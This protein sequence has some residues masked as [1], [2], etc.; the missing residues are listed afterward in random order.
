LPA[1]A[2]ADEPPP[3]QRLQWG[4]YLGV[5][6]F[7]DDSGLG[8]DE[9]APAG[10]DIK[11]GV[12]LG[13]RLTW[14]FHD[15]FAAEGEIEILPTA[16]Q[17]DRADLTQ[18]GYRAHGLVFFRDAGV[19]VRPFA[20]V[21]VGGRS[22]L[23]SDERVIG[24]GTSFAVD[25]GV[26]VFLGI[27]SRWGL[28][29]DLRLGVGPDQGGTL[30][31]T[32]GE[33][34]VG[35]YFPLGRRGPEPAWAIANRER[36]A[37]ERR[38]AAG[39]AAAEAAKSDPDDADDDGL[40][41]ADDRCPFDAEDKDGVDDGDGCPDRDE[42]VDGDGDGVFGHM[43]KC[44][45]ERETVNGFDD[46]DGCPDR[47][48]AKT[49]EL[50]GTIDGVNFKTG[51]ATI[52]K[53]SYAVLDRAAKLLSD[54]PKLR[55]TIVGHTDDRGARARNVK[56]SARRA[57]AVKKY[58]VKAGVGAERLEAVGKGPDEPLYDNRSADGRA[59]NRRIEFV[60]TRE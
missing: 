59:G 10:S 21:G 48:D 57:Q 54:D 47:I 24:D 42:D 58:L 7:D 38:E 14:H 1:P 31:A 56:L 45:S 46:G 12:P 6:L 53:S 49:M 44:P 28:R 35:L 36:D 3:R 41:D 26:G 30:A 9:S 13:A 34:L 22:Q 15:V 55:L 52:A 16:S 39:E 32:D 11:N 51:S 29:V 19:R 27:A 17:N 37:R 40:R 18:F 50:T 20:L 23:S 8:R 2:T 43:D 60:L 25:G 5:H 4:A 33:V